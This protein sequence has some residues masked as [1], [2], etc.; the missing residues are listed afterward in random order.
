MK[1]LLSIFLLLFLSVSSF[2]Q[3]NH[4]LKRCWTQQCKPLKTKY[5]AVKYTET[6]K[7]LNHDFQ[8]WKETK[9]ETKGEL[10]MNKNQFIKSDS[11][12]DGPKIYTSKTQSNP[13]YLLYLDYGEEKLM[14]ITETMFENRIMKTMRYSPLQMLDF[15]KKNA[16]EST[17]TT[18]ECCAI[19]TQK[20]N[21]NNVQLSI[22]KQSNLLQKISVTA[23]D[24]LYG[25]V[26]T[27]FNYTDYGKMG[28]LTVANT[29][30]IDRIDAKIKEEVHL[31]S[32]VV[33]DVAP[34]F[35]EKPLDYTIK[36]NT[37]ISPEIKV[38]K[39]SPNLH[40]IEMKH[41]DDKVLLV[42]F[43]DFCLVAEAPLSPEN[44]A[45][46]IA[47]VH[48]I[49]PN[50]PIKYFVFGHHHP[51]YLGGVRAFVREG[52]TVL[53]ASSSMPY[54]E[55]I[56]QAPHTLQPDA[57]QQN[58]QKLKI[59]PIITSKTITDGDFEMQIHFIGEKSKHTN[60][61][62]IYYFPKEKL[63]FEDDLVWIAK[64][65]EL[66]KAGQRQAGLYQAIKDLG[67]E[68]ETIVQSWPVA[69]YGVKTVLPFA[70]LEMSVRK[71]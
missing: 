64:S 54:V 12:G 53:S 36:S 6:I 22:N 27:N 34:T 43:K 5:L 61:Y 67:L 70:D 71:E 8:P 4:H 33:A 38:E 31:T 59:E 7:E 63:L 60:D 57:L 20:I 35:L 42:E 18:T 40:F 2:A 41:T 9:Y 10:W 14:E 1:I 32:F 11:L 65:G 62:L 19:Y 46:I 52:A 3:K 17:F 25:D 16:G 55:Y 39:Y 15:F 26:V 69:D 13:K 56:V 66:K 44:G 37:Q 24:D 29:I 58:P 48:K 28:D 45:Q 21:Q 47:E 51:H 49:A 23:H 50:K 30:L 68:V